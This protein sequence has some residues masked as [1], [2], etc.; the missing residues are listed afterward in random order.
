M[1]NF[2]RVGVKFF[3]ILASSWI[4]LA[5]LLLVIITVGIRD[6]GIISIKEDALLIAGVVNS[7][8]DEEDFRN[9]SHDELQQEVFPLTEVYDIKSVHFFREHNQDNPH[10]QYVFRTK[11]ETIEVV[12][13]IRGFSVYVYFPYWSDDGEMLGVVSVMLDAVQ[14]RKR[15]FQ[16]ILWIFVLIGVVIVLEL[17]F[18]RKIFS[19]YVQ[20][21]NDFREIIAKTDSGDFKTRLRTNLKDEIADIVRW[22]NAISAKIDLMI[23]NIESR[24][25]I[26]MN[27]QKDRYDANPLVRIH[28]AVDELVDVYQFKQH[29]EKL[30][31]NAIQEV[32]VQLFSTL[33][34]G[35][36]VFI[37]S[38]QAKD[39]LIHPNDHTL[40]RAYYQALN[41]CNIPLEPRNEGHFYP[42]TFCGK[43]ALWTMFR[44]GGDVRWEFIFL[45]D[46]QHFIKTFPLL[47]NYFE[48]ARSTIENRYLMDLLKINSQK[49]A[50]TGLNNRAFLEEFSESVTYQAKRIELKYAVMMV[51]ID[52]FK[53]VNDN[54]GHNIGDKVLRQLAQVFNK[55]IRES[56][57]SVRYGGEE[58]LLLLLG[59]PQKAGVHV[60]QKIKESFEQ[61]VFESDFN[62]KFSCTLSVGLSCFPDDADDMA[63][64]IKYADMALYE[65]KRSG[66]N[67][68]VCFERGMIP[69]DFDPK[70]V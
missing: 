55:I 25:P 14:S 10:V 9:L 1:F 12:D 7:K 21:Y 18:L 41:V 28:A 46:E 45:G 3:W 66:R 51:D 61:I 49:D 15:W 60:A 38:T 52:Y 43:S 64:S 63:L 70:K 68:I 22:I 59:C 39:R 23:D 5:V 50:L 44:V 47:C 4:I 20:F 17:L 11:Q 62:E 6:L 54:Y 48:T 37:E 30:K 67:R 58:F 57:L 56:D 19:P 42:V 26:L 69:R 33:N 32:F 29:I 24:I 35:D 8:I 31:I 40:L 13:E 34:L 2:N 16:M 36:V 65:A 53:K 27:Y